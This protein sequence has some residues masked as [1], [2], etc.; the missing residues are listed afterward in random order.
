MIFWF[1]DTLI[2]DRSG[3]SEAH[4]HH[5]SIAAARQTPVDGGIGADG[6]YGRPHVLQVPDFDR[7]VVTAG[8]H[9]VSER[10]DGRRH[11]AGRSTHTSHTSAAELARARACERL[12]RCGPG[13]R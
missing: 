5:A 4:N 10:E 8:H 9:V 2:L 12:T 6:C 7:A 1:T 3:E 11:R 13:R